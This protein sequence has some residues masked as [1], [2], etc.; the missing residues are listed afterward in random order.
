MV[1]ANF[2]LGRWQEGAKALEASSC[3]SYSSTN[4]I[5]VLVVAMVWALGLGLVGQ[6][7]GATKAVVTILSL[8]LLARPGDGVSKS[9]CSNN[10]KNSCCCASQEKL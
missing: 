8:G 9:C 3:G 10:H 1:A 2:L 4:I 6:V 5:A 7:L